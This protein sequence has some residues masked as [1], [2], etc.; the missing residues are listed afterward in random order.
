MA[1]GIIEP[2]ITNK[3]SGKSLE[4]AFHLLE[5][6]YVMKEDGLRP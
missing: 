5:N 3:G 1:Y 6:H 2:T 4:V